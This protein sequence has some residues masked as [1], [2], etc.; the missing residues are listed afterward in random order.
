VGGFRRE[1]SIVDFVNS[2]FTLNKGRPIPLSAGPGGKRK[3]LRGEKLKCLSPWQFFQKGREI[4]ADSWKRWEEAG[5]AAQG[6]ID[7]EALGRHIANL[8]LGP[9]DVLA[10]FGCG[11]GELLAAASPLV[12]AATGIDVS[13]PQVERARQRLKGLD[14]VQV[15]LSPFL[16]WNPQGM[17]YSRGSARKALHHLT[18]DEKFRF[19]VNAGLHFQPGSLFV[20]EDVLFAFEKEE[21]NEMMPRVEMEA[22]DFYGPRW[23]KARD[24]FLHTLFQEFP[25]GKRVMEEAMRGG[26]FQPVEWKPVTCFYGILTARKAGGGRS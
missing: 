2:M 20:V 17:T 8:C 12:K 7:G 9:Q 16:E 25:T 13:P 11:S 23:E 6:S 5:P 26:G 24:I 14:N 15:I 19:F 3:G 18:D 4:M 22:R 1:Y 10:D 21:Q